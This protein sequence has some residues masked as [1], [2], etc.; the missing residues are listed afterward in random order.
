MKILTTSEMREADRLT[1]E[2]HGIASLSL[3]ENAGSAVAQFLAAHFSP[4]ERRRFV[5]LC[6]KGNNGGDGFVVAR[7]LREC[8]AQ[9]FIFLFADPAELLGDAAANF[10]RLRATAIEAKIIRDA[11]AWTASRD[12]LAGAAVIVDAL[13]GTG[14]RGSVDG[15]P[16]QVIQDVNRHDARACVIAVDIPSGLLGDTGEAAGPAVVAD[17]TITFT[18]PK[19]GMVAAS[20]RPFVGRLT[21]A[22]IGSPR[23]LL[24]EISRSKVRWLEPWEF[25][26]L[27]TGRKADSNKGLY[28]HALIVAGSLGKAGSAA[29][30]AQSALRVGAGLVTVAT[31]EPVLAT[32]A[33]FAPEIMTEPLHATRA[34]TIARDVFDSG[35]FAKILEGKN[36]L[37]LGPGLTTHEET[38]QF[39]RSIIASRPQ[40]PIILDADGLNAFAGRAGELR[41]SLEMLALTPHPGEM[42]RLLG[43]TVKE[44]QS[45]RLEVALKAAA[46]WQAF[47]IL[48]GYQT[49]LA[50]PNGSAWINSTGNP[51]MSTGGTGDVLTGMLAG[52]TAEFGA[53]S[54]P[55][56][57]ARGVYL[58]GLAGDLAAE[59]FGESSLIA[60]DVIRA[61]PAACAQFRDAMQ[62]L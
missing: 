61:I 27:S 8:G 32:V 10:Q 13:F 23:E 31:P 42:A 30:A 16:A 35:G 52:L 17:Y 2:R 29:L 49:I 60:S 50:A 33:G 15:L 21:V 45:R 44:V 25:R 43:S 53:H 48:K 18:A 55:L 14:L 41:G 3:M 38:Q 6:G 46:D 37:A 39:V 62:A 5:V 4:L 20:A 7:K 34:G 58:H 56:T 26:G 47:V 36:V 59:E 51:G 28:G 19:V 1:T 57:L 40:V 22:D 24:D 9:P 12:L 54:W 11:V